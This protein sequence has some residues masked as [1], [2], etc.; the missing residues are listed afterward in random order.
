MLSEVKTPL[1]N[2]AQTNIRLCASPSFASLDVLN[3]NKAVRFFRE[4]SS[5]E[6]QTP[7]PHSSD[8]ISKQRHRL[9]QKSRDG[10]RVS[11]TSAISSGRASLLAP[12]RTNS[13]AALCSVVLFVIHGRF[14]AIACL[15]LI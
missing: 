1:F 12:I 14:N 8:R 15:K 7:D 11:P 6:Y 13:L 4:T 10:G 2:H 9:E 3:L 5:D